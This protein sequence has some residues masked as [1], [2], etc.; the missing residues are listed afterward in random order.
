MSSRSLSLRYILSPE[1]LINIDQCRQHVRVYTRAH[2]R[3][4]TR[5]H[6][7]AEDHLL[8]APPLMAAINSV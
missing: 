7:G 1:D 3:Q 5:M 6:Y 4:S 2:G 8:M